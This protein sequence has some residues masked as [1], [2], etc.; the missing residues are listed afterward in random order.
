MLELFGLSAITSTMIL[1]TITLVITIAPIFIWH[2]CKKINQRLE[3]LNKGQDIEI[4]LFEELIEL[5][6]KHS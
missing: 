3:E 5:I 2:Y 1:L 6:K 4:Q